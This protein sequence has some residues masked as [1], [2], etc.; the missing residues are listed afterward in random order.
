MKSIVVTEVLTQ[1][2]LC[3]KARCT[4]IKKW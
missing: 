1:I 4:S 3:M 2:Y